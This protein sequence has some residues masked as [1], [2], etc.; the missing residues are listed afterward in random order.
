MRPVEDCIWEIPTTEKPGMRVPARVVA[1]PEAMAE[2]FGSTAHGAG[3]TM[4]RAQ[5]KREVRGEKL[6]AEMEGRGIL[7]R[8]ASRSGVAEEAGVAYKDLSAVVEVLRRL[9]LS[10]KVASL[11]PIGNIKG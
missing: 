11:A 7:V 6:L 4:S 9:R 8:A 10:R 2:T 3:R 1:T 5:A